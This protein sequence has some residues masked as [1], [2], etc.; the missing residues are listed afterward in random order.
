MV[1]TCFKCSTE[2]PVADFYRHVGMADGRLNKCKACCHADDVA[3]RVR[4]WGSLAAFRRAS[5]EREL[6]LGTRTRRAPQKYG[7]DPE[8]RRAASLRYFHKRRAQTQ[9]HS[10]L[11][12]F[13]FDEAIR[14][15]VLRTR[16]TG[17]EW[18]VDHIVPL[19]HK[20]ICGLHNAFNLQVVPGSWNVKKQHRSVA[21]YW[22]TKATGM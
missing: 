12:R 14:L 1:K 5:Y 16:L 17:I 6:E 3:Y 13:V 2:K 8:S 15:R 18:H 11:D 7:K 21:T 20:S 10:D 19:N 22:P 4:R 9:A